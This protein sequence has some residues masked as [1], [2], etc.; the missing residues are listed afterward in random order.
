MPVNPERRWHV[1]RTIKLRY[2]APDACGRHQ[3]AGL[4]R[5]AVKW[6][7]CPEKLA[8]KAQS[9]GQALGSPSAWQR[10]P[11]CALSRISAAADQCLST[12][13]RRPPCYWEQFERDPV[14]DLPKR[15][16]PS[17]YEL[18]APFRLLGR[19]RCH[20]IQ[21]PYFDQ[22]NGHQDVGETAPL[23][24]SRRCVRRSAAA[25]RQ[26]NGRLPSMT[27]T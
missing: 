8:T 10:W 23:I 19:C 1:T 16:D 12:T 22:A 14:C 21:A 5:A 17:P 6:R 24:N 4:L 9:R 7:G 18:S 3:E 2:G 20:C 26:C 27:S 11:A 15:R 13:H 25:Y